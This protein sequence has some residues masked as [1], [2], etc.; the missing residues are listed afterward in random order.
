MNGLVFLPSITIHTL[1]CSIIFFIKKKIQKYINVRNFFLSLYNFVYCLLFINS[2]YFLQYLQSETH[3]L[4]VSLPRILFLM[5]RALP[6]ISAIKCP[7]R[8][9]DWRP[10]SAI[11][12]LLAMLR[13][14]RELNILIFNI[15]IAMYTIRSLN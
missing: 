15:F 14:F 1:H 5:Y 9:L 13:D 10:S 7:S 3:S 8:V 2:A 6:K 4:F 11:R 12:E